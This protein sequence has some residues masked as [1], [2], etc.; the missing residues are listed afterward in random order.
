[1]AQLSRICHVLSD[2]CKIC[3]R[4][5]D[6]YLKYLN[7]RLVELITFPDVK[8]WPDKIFTHMSHSM[9]HLRWIQCYEM[10]YIPI[11]WGSYIKV[12]KFWAMPLSYAIFD[13]W[14]CPVK[15]FTHVSHAMIQPPYPPLDMLWSKICA[16]GSFV[17]SKCLFLI[18]IHSFL[19]SEL[20]YHNLFN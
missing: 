15:I 8:P 6:I 11:Q 1:M 7:W 10:P 2:K 19:T 13:T 17:F 16:E 18:Y 14:P 4:V 3:W 12:V 20:I 5:I 9:I